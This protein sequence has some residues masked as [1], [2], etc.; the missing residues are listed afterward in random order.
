MEDRVEIEASQIG[1]VAAEQLKQ[2]IERIE[3]LED[4]K[5][6]L[7]EDIRDIFAEAKASGFDVKVMRQVIKE[8]KLDANERDEQETLLAVYKKALNM[9]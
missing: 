2:Y 1:G 8:R 6:S 7:A 3:R 5:K 4:E 9:A